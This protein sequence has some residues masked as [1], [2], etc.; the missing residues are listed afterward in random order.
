[1][2]ARASSRYIGFQGRYYEVVAIPGDSEFLG[3]IAVP[4]HAI[5]FDVYMKLFMNSAMSS[6]S[7]LRSQPDRGGPQAEL[8]KERQHDMF[9]E[10]FRAPIDHDLYLRGLPGETEKIIDNRNAI[11]GMRNP[12]QS[13]VKVKGHATVGPKVASIITEYLRAHPEVKDILIS[14]LGKSK[15]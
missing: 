15:G 12:A 1:M 4:D 5:N 11:G 13:N 8:D 14:S 9:E 7:S 3:S 6:M 2:R 10:G